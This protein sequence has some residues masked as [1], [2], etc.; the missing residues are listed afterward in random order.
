[1]KLMMRIL[2]LLLAASAAYAQP[3][4][5]KPYLQFGDN[6]ADPQ[7]MSVLWH[8]ADRDGTFAVQWRQGGGKWSRPAPASS[9]RIAVRSIEP[10]R[11]WL[12]ALA[13]L[14]P[15]TAFEYQVL[16][17]G[18]PVFQATAKTRKSSRQPYRFAL[19]GDS[20]A[21]TPEQRVIAAQVAASKP[22]FVFI[23]GDIVYS[24]GR[25]SEY[26]EKYFPFYES[27][28]ASVP[29]AAA[30]GNHDIA[31][32]DVRGNPDAMGYFHYFNLPLNGPEGVNAPPLEGP[33]QDRAAVIAASNGKFPRMANYSFDYGNSHWLVI[34]ANRWVDFKDPKLRAWIAAD[35]K[36]SRATWKFVAVHQPGFNSS[37]AHF[38]EQ[39]TR[40]VSDLFEA[41]GVDIVWAGHV[42]NYQRSFPMKFANASGPDLRGRVSG[43][44]TLDKNYDGATR[45]RPNGPIYIVSGAG[46]AGLYDKEQETKPGSWQAF[47]HKFI[48]TTHSFS[49][50]DVDGKKLTV[51][52]LDTQG[53]ELDRFVI[54]K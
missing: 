32:P 14:K 44:W 34:D 2:P 16:E 39:R 6:P 18:K 46:G 40:L 47:T 7:K 23:T 24:R 17:A 53:R 28:I 37:D 38:N 20:G 8:T 26:R 42:H 49:V 3:F 5:V 19:F 31:T 48:S 29:V 35:L 43:D 51:R 27:L 54:T 15:G 4:L 13:G 22:D 10:H 21:G 33:E 30:P 50:A 52:Q 25:I 12:A 9:H 41:G 11:V 1:M 36:N 45:T